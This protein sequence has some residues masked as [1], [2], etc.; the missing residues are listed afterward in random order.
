MSDLLQMKQKN[1]NNTD[2]TPVIS[3]NVVK[4]WYERF[5]EIFAGWRSQL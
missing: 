5:Y 3:L 1:I 4:K 2:V